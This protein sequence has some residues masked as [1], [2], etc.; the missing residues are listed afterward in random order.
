MKAM[1]K[2]LEI[3]QPAAMAHA[4]AMLNPEKRTTLKKAME[5]SS[6]LM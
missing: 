5:G 3:K 6:R 4:W 1:L 2:W